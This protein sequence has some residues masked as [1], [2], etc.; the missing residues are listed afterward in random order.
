MS[1]NVTKKDLV[2]LIAGKIQMSKAEVARVINSLLEE[3]KGQFQKGER[4]EL[5]GFGAFFPYKRK[6]RKTVVP[7]TGEVMMTEESIHLKFKGSDTVVKKE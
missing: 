6:S 3:I 5:R 2:D 1:D 4:I 7:R